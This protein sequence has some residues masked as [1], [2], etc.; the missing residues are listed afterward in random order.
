MNLSEDRIA[1]AIAIAATMTTGT[2]GRIAQEPSSRWLTL[3]CAVHNGMA[4]AA[5]AE[6]GLYGDSMVLEHLKQTF[7]AARFADALSSS[8]PAIVQTAFKPYCTGRQSLAAT[9]AFISLCSDETIEPASIERIRVIVPPQY[10]A[11]IDR[12]SRPKNKVESR[13][14]RYQLAIAALYPDDL[15]DLD[16]RH[17]RTDDPEICRITDMIEVEG[18]TSLGKMYPRAWPGAVAI[19]C[20]GKTFER[21]VVHPNGDPERPLTWGDIDLKLR[22]IAKHCRDPLRVS[23][24]AAAAQQLDFGRAMALF[25]APQ[26]P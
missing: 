24:L 16:R 15:F 4:A 21:S 19:Q 26:Q 25:S 9:E 10:R 18:S 14:V 3:G 20:G 13:G 1:T 12:P 8:V 23:D 22:S 7:A 17:L 11:M 2:T 5:G 6:A